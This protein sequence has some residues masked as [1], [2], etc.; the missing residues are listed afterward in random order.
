MVREIRGLCPSLDA[1]F[2]L[3]HCSANV[4]ADFLAKMEVELEQGKSDLCLSAL[5]G[6]I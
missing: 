3:V 6:W 2:K 4:V 1:S 5:L